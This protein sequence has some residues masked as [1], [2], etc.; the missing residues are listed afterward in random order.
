LLGLN[1]CDSNKKVF[2][3]LSELISIV[4]IYTIYTISTVVYINV[5]YEMMVKHITLCSVTQ[6]SSEKIGILQR[7]PTSNRALKNS[8]RYRN[9]IIFLTKSWCEW[10]YQCYNLVKHDKMKLKIVIKCTQKNII[11]LEL[12]MLIIMIT[13]ITFFF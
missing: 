1:F 3:K 11:L 13:P 7:N 12:L 2:L 9:S 8:E 6:S 4:Y 10:N 5:K